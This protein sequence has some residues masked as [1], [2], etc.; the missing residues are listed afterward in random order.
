[1]SDHILSD[2]GLPPALAAALRA[3]VATDPAAKRRVMTRVRALPLPGRLPRRWRAARPGW[4]GRLGLSPLAGLVA[5]AG[6]AGIVTVGALR[7]PDVARG[8]FG[9]AAVSTTLRDTLT[10]GGST[11]HDTLRL[12][13]FALA[14]PAAA[15]VALVGDFNAWNARA[16][17]LAPAAERRGTWVAA[18]AL[19]PGA[20]R[21]AFVL[22]DTQWTADPRAIPTR[23][24]TGVLR[25]MI[26]PGAN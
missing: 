16:T 14:A 17:P 7:A 1:M 24:D 26:V 15:R 23:G 3:P 19:P 20:H 21:Y 25:T 10:L 11:L 2:D 6:F 18:V 5:A 9:A 13:R 8:A 4:R 22:D 12:V